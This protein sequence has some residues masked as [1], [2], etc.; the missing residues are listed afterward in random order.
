MVNKCLLGHPKT[1]KHT[2]QEEWI[3]RMWYINTI[4]YHAAIK[5]NEIIPFAATWI[6]LESVILSE[7]KKQKHPLYAESKRT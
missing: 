7:S 1:V 5:K 3:K 2:H 4:E 6:D